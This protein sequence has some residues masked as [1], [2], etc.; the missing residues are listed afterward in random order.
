MYHNVDVVANGKSYISDIDQNLK[1]C[2]AQ[3]C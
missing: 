3:N 2:T 1:V